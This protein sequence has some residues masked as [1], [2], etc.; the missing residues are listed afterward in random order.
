MSRTMCAAGMLVVA[1]VIAITPPAFAADAPPASQPAASQPATV[2]P[3]TVAKA[4]IQALCDGDMNKAASY[5]LPWLRTNEILEGRGAF[6][7]SWGAFQAACAKAFG[8]PTTQP[9]KPSTLAQQAFDAIDAA[10]ER[11]E[12]DLAMILTHDEPAR[13]ELRRVDGQ[14]KIDPQTV[15]AT[16][17]GEYQPR[18]F[19]MLKRRDLAVA[20]ARYDVAAE[21]AAGKYH[22]LDEAKRALA[23]REEREKL[24]LRDAVQKGQ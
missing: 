10:R 7:Q 15:Y 20:K 21:V 4:F 11:S 22:T 23:D 8:G 17:S 24:A 19:D 16:R 12:G 18:V 2:P 1:V 13:I 5:T 6:Y 3:K 9:G 14:W